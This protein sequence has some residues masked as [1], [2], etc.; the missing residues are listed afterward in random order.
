MR[1]KKGARP[2]RTR[3]EQTVAVEGAKVR[4]KT[5]AYEAACAAVL[6]VIHQE[7]ERLY[8]LLSERMLASDDPRVK[9]AMN[10]VRC[11]LIDS[12]PGEVDLRMIEEPDLLGLVGLRMAE[13]DGAEQLA[14]HL[15][16]YLVHLLM[17]FS[18]VDEKGDYT[19]SDG[20]TWSLK[21]LRAMAK[22]QDPK[23]EKR[24]RV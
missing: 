16:P 21:R 20:T 17:Q 14:R 10:A 24:K 15:A 13:R 6:G 9:L 19:F 8:G 18:I 22:G 2:V 7:R 1:S 12:A 11:D 5:K 3:E 23:P 4:R